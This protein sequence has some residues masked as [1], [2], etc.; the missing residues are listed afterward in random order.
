MA[1]DVTKGLILEHLKAIQNRLSNL[2]NGQADIK[3]TLIS[4]QQHMAGFM[5]NASAHES[6]IATLQARLDRIARRL[7]LSD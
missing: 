2:E 1:D 7:E 4:L 3:T 6:A 5:T